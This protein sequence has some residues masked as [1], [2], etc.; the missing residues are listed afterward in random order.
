MKT[1]LIVLSIALLT[2]PTAPAFSAE[3]ASSDKSAKAETPKKEGKKGEKKTT[4]TP[5]EEAEVMIKALSPTQRAKLLEIL[6]KG[7]DSALTGL[8]GIGESR[9]AAIKKARPFATP[10]D[11]INVKGIGSAGLADIVAHAKAGFPEKTKQLE[12][13]KK[14][15]ASETKEDGTAKSNSKSKSKSKSKAKAKESDQAKGSN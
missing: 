10:A 11:L 12:P 14:A 5:N 3:K 8:P 4:V 7:D 9:V 1:K 15:K 6:N 2:L 13:P